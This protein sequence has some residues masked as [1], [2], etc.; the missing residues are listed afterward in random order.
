MS[1][2]VSFLWESV[3]ATTDAVAPSQLPVVGAELRLNRQSAAEDVILPDM[4]RQ[5]RVTSPVNCVLAISGYDI[6]GNFLKPTNLTVTGGTPLSW[7]QML[8][9]VKSISC[10]ST[11]DATQAIK[12]GY[13]ALGYIGW[14]PLDSHRR[15]AN[16]TFQVNVLT[17][18]VGSTFQCQIIGNTLKAGLLPPNVYDKIQ[19]TYPTF[20]DAQSQYK[21]QLTPASPLLFYSTASGNAPLSPFVLSG[22]NAITD[23]FMSNSQMPLTTVA[24]YVGMTG[25]VDTTFSMLFTILQQGSN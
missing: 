14:T 20:G 25:T 21:Y 17:K 15:Y 24:A 16:T 10:V 8:H 4:M 12:V 23:N 5:I 19:A 2:P 11:T 9:R 3:D 22:M 13:G 6:F 18:A 7:P 1:T